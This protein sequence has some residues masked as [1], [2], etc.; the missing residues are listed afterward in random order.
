MKIAMED[1]LV[2]YMTKEQAA[3]IEVIFNF[4]F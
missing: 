1:R 2:Y 3:L 4:N